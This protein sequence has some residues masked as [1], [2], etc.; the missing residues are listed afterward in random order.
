MGMFVGDEEAYVFDCICNETNCFDNKSQES[1]EEIQRL[2][3]NNAVLRELLGLSLKK[4]MKH[5]FENDHCESCKYF[6]ET[7]KNLSNHCHKCNFVSIYND[8]TDEWEW[9]YQEL[10]NRIQQNEETE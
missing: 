4:N 1:K 2:K 6:D 10:F 8:N 5:D 9:K 7:N 3:Q